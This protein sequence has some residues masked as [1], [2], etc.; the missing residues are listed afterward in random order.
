MAIL[1]KLLGSAVVLAGANAHESIVQLKLQK[2]S[3]SLAQITKYA[4]ISNSISKDEFSEGNTAWTSD[5]IAKQA[6]DF[7]NNAQAK[8][9][10]VDNDA[11]AALNEV[12]SGS[13]DLKKALQ[14]D[15]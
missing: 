1:S 6:I 15:Q 3:L 13:D 9:K 4:D 8:Q 7:S 5:T 12:M 10:G 2:P 11:K 14:M